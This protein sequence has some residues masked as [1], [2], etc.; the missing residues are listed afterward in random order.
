M[1]KTIII[2]LTIICL[3]FIGCGKEVEEIDELKDEKEI[4]NLINSYQ[5]EGT[6]GF[7]YS[8]EQKLNESIINSHTLSI[9][10]DNSSELK[11]SREEY[12][13][14]LNEDITKEQFSELNATAYY[15]NNKIATYE[16]D[17]WV[18]KECRISEFASVNIN[19]FN[20]DISKLS[21]L[22]LSNEGSYLVLTFNVSDSDA[23]SFLG[24]K[25]N[26]RDLSFKIKVLEES[27]QLVSFEMNYLQDSTKTFFSFIPYYGSVKIELPE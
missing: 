14:E 2:L 11:G 20:L 12:K 8:L 16:K 23:S 3:L 10:L 22:K 24:V 18:W 26:I 27:K 4:L 9:R 6:N 21:N 13:K 7:D 1:R 15:Y 19:S 25:G 17:S 5:V